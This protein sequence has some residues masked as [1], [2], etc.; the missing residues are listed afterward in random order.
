MTQAV[1]PSSPG[2]MIAPK[3]SSLPR[4][5]DRLPLGSSLHVSPICLGASDV[6]VVEEAFA[7][8]I[9]FFF[10]SVDLHWHIYEG[11]RV[12]IRRLLQKNPAARREMVILAVSYTTQRLNFT[13]AV[14]LVMELPEMGDPDA[15]I[16]GCIYGEETPRL[17]ALRLER[18][19][20]KAIG[21]SFH[22]RSAALQC[23]Q[24]APLDLSF[25][26]YN[27]QHPGLEVD[28]LPFLPER[29]GLL[30]SFKS[31]RSYVSPQRMEELG[32]PTHLW[33]PTRADHYRFALSC[34]ALDGVLVSLRNV[35]QLDELEAALARGPLSDRQ[36][37][38][39]KNLALLNNG[40]AVLGS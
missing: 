14:D 7:R 31:M 4:F 34:P 2:Q 15:L 17:E 27:P 30:Y 24:E 21:A 16:S 35:S 40:S 29:R 6:S 8:G 39:L 12:G 33:R 10:L 37:S 22:E 19:N 36:C 1:L 20:V 3:K 26:R 38:F 11:L 32:L 5:T 28:M 13:G 18:P 9:N 25:V 23:M